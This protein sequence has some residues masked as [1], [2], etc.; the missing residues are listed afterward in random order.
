MKKAVILI[1]FCSDVENGTIFRS[2]ILSRSDKVLD[3]IGDTKYPRPGP[4]P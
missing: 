2:A 3:A 4:Y 1:L